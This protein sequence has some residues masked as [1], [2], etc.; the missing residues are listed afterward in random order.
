M[1]EDVFFTCCDVIINVSCPSKLKLIQNFLRSSMSQT[2]LTNLVLLSIE[3]EYAKK[4][5]F[6]EV[7]DKFAEI[8]A[9]KER[10]WMFLYFFE[11]MLNLE[12]GFSVTFS[13]WWWFLCGWRCVFVIS[14]FAEYFMSCIFFLF[15]NCLLEYCNLLEIPSANMIFFSCVF[16]FK[17]IHR[18]GGC[19]RKSRPQVPSTLGTPLRGGVGHMNWPS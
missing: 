12:T 18:G 3:H 11:Y 16:I 1:G 7:I 17:I 8:K 9:G 5:N 15:P 13:Y 2:R 10:L 19:Q 6:D 4:V 14:M